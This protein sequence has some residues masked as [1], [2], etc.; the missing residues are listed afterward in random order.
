MRIE[1][2]GRGVDGN[3]HTCNHHKILLPRY[4]WREMIT[5]MC[6]RARVMERDPLVEG[7][8]FILIN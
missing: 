4:L 6:R 7:E 1:K 8:H 5:V 2:N 3:G